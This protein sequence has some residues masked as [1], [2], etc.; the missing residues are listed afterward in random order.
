MHINDS[1]QSV[2]SDKSSLITQ[3]RIVF[4]THI[5]QM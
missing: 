2:Q 4:I 5:A 3:R 1:D